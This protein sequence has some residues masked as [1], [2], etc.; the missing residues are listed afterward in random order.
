MRGVFYIS[1]GS[2][3]SPKYK[4]I[5]HILMHTM[6][7]RIQYDFFGSIVYG[8]DEIRSNFSSANSVD[9]ISR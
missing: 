7:S 5:A 2:S 4:N 9:E 3:G 8:T 1:K 6:N